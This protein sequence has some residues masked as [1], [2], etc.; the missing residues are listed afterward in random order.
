MELKDLFSGGLASKRIKLNQI[1]FASVI[2]LLM[3]PRNRFFFAGGFTVAFLG[4]LLRIWAKGTLVKDSSE[5]ATAGPYRLVRHPMYL[6]TLLECAGLVVACFNFRWFFSWIL[7]LMVVSFYFAVVYKEAM[8]LE[9]EE[10]YDRHAARWESYCREV[11]ALFPRG[12][13]LRT[14]SWRDFKSFQFRR[15]E[16]S[17]EWNS[18][19][20]FL[21]ISFLLWIKLVYR[22]F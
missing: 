16:N 2:I 20:I 22:L 21:G 10:M 18:F 11:P 5:L 8:L 7:L 1:F 14:L 6:G 9:E 19:L 13:D 12:S 15:F 17:K 3:H 4:A